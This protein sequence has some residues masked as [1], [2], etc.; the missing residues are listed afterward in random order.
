D[1]VRG[2]D[3]IVDGPLTD[4]CQAIGEPPGAGRDFH[5][6]DH[7]D[8]VPRGAL[9]VFEANLDTV[10]RAGGGGAARAAEPGAAAGPSGLAASG[11]GS[12]AP[13][14]GD[15]ALGGRRRA[16]SA[17]DRRPLHRPAEPGRPP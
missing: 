4:R 13:A 9:S 3:D 17:E 2:V 8:H 11:A 5:A 10:Y 6:A 15:A 12:A 16:P 14:G 1:V 7:R